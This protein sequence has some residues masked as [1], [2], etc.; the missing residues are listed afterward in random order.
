M[1]IVRVEDSTERASI[2]QAA[3][4]EI[5]YAGLKKIM[6]VSD[7]EL[8]SR[9]HCH[10]QA[11]LRTPGDRATYLQITITLF[12]GRTLDTKRKLYAELVEQLSQSIGIEPSSVLI[13]LDEHD[14][15]NWGM[16]GGI[17]A[18]EIDF[19]YSVMV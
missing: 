15:H 11:T 13:L 9:Y 6:G 16:R 1:P 4:I 12:R 18:S 8:Q 5:I 2:D 7:E 10:S 17:P 19:G 14:A 3:I